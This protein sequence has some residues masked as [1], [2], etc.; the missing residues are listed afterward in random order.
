MRAIRIPSFTTPGVSYAVG[1][2]GVG[3]GLACDCPAWR[4]ARPCKHVKVYIAVERAV[5]RCRDAGHHVDVVRPS[6]DVVCPTCLASALVASARKA[7][8][9]T[10]SALD[11][12]KA[13]F[14]M[15]KKHR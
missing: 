14:K 4:Q 15:K 11:D 12:L 9:R 7:K 6:V 1:P 3:A 8:S 10:R 5:A 13:R 2:R